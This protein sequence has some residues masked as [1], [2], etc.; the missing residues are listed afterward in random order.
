MK[1]LHVSLELFPFVK[2]GGIADAVAALA[3]TLATHGH[4]VTV[5]LPRRDGVRLPAEAAPGVAIAPLDVPELASGDLYGHDVMETVEEAA[6][7]ARLSCAVLDLVGASARG[8]EPFDVVHVHDWPLAMI[9]YLL[10]ERRAASPGTR[11]VLTIHN[12]GF[13]GIVLPDALGLFRLG[14]EHLTEE[15]LLFHGRASMLKGGLVAADALT[16]VSP[17]YARDLTTPEHGHLLD[18]VIRARGDRVHGILNG[19]DTR[20]W[21]PST[22]PALP[23]RYDA[24]DLSGKRACKQALLEELGLD[25]DPARPLFAHV[26][27]LFH[28]KGA[29]LLAEAL[30]P[31]AARGANVVVAGTGEPALAEAVREAAAACP[32]RAAALGWVPEETVHRL[33]A[34]SDAVLVPSRVEP[35]GLAQ[36]YAQRYG[37]LPVAHRTGGLADT[38]VD[39]DAEPASGTGFLYDAPTAES[40]LGAVDRAMAR[41]RAGALGDAIARAMGLVRDWSRP[42]AQIDFVYQQVKSAPPR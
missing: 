17:A 34:A 32:G 26:G 29:D 25:P 8:G 40:L 9:P 21:D 20:V 16:T 36:M 13:Q 41:W 4:R 10:R 42:A 23:A 18:D 39:V 14:P 6:R 1:V 30:P 7:H 15:R 35:C 22:D 37:A 12:V 38:I 19:I 33:F 31:I 3:K 28:E 2:V 5:A 24:S 11:S 27:R